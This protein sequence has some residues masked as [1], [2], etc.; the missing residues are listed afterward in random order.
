MNKSKN[1][2]ENI[3]TENERLL[4]HISTSEKKMNDLSS[5]LN[6][7]Y[8]DCLNLYKSTSKKLTSFFD[9]SKVSEVITKTDQNMIFFYQTSLIFLNSFSNI[10]EKFNHIIII[11]LNEYKINYTKENNIIKKDFLLLL[12]DFKKEKRKLI[13]YQNKYYKSLIDYINIKNKYHSLTKTDDEKSYKLYNEMWEKK[14]IMKIQKQL[15][16]YKIG[17]INILYK[18]Y[19]LRYKKYYRS[20]ENNERNRLIFLY[21]TFRIFSLKMK[22]L[23]ESINEFSFQINSKFNEW[24]IEEDKNI[25]KEEFNYIGRYINDE[26]IY[27]DSN[28]VQRFNKEI[29]MPY[30]LQNMNYVNNF[31]NDFNIL[32]RKSSK[33]N[34]ALLEIID[35]NE[36]NNNNNIDELNNKEV[37][38]NFIDK[39][40]EYLYNNNEDI[41]FD[42][43]INII[44]M[45]IKDNNYLNKF[46]NNYYLEN[47][48][49]YFQINRERNI[50]HLAH[51]FLNI[52]YSI[53]E[54]NETDNE[55]NKKIIIKLLKIGQLIYYISNNK[56]KMQNIF[57]CGLINKYFEFQ[58]DKFWEN[59]ILYKIENKLKKLFIKVERNGNKEFKNIK[60]FKE[61]NLDILINNY[62]MFLSLINLNEK[63]N[64]L[65]DEKEKIFF[66]NAFHSLHKIILEFINYLINY[67]FGY[68][69]CIC[70]I[71]KICKKFNLKNELISFY[72][73]YINIISFSSKQYF[74]NF[75]SK[76]KDKL[77][78]IKINSNIN[79]SPNIND[80]NKLLCEKNKIIIILNISKFLNNNYKIKLLRLNKYIYGK[81]HKKIYKEILYFSDKMNEDKNKLNRIHISIWKNLLK[82]SDIKQKYPYEVNKRKIFSKKYLNYEQSDFYIIDLDCQRTLFENRTNTLKNGL[83]PN[84]KGQ[85]FNNYNN[86]NE[87][88]NNINNYQIKSIEMK[89]MSLN[90]ILKTLITLNPEQTYCQ[91]MNFIGVFLLKILNDKEEDT[92]YFMAGLFKYT[93]YPQIF[94]DNL[95]QLKLYFNIFNQLLFIFIPNL[96]DYFK[97]NNIIPNYYLSSCFITLFTNYAKE[98]KLN[99]FIKIFDLFIIDG[100][101]A[102]FNLL[103]DI[104]WH[105]EEK[106]MNLKN[107]NLL[108]YLNGN[109][110]NDFFL[111][112]K[113]YNYFE[114][115]NQRKVTNKLIKNIEDIIVSSNQLGIPFD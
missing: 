3:D 103:L 53:K 113:E 71:K 87:I 72:I 34:D 4:K 15:Y 86:S 6:N 100:W 37:E 20:F 25:I 23:S 54:K 89:R 84:F 26:N 1:Y 9:V 97:S 114:L 78:H 92:F 56:M 32:K 107:E 27:N 82:Y 91:G 52:L 19:D 2:Y 47:K 8:S 98:K 50:K 110:I 62:D 108:H 12:K 46:I 67:N 60:V 29:Y 68:N 66:K 58:N 88:I 44:E 65:S 70:L 7:I 64:I 99:L 39:F 49:K 31:Y 21:N 14:S 69:N 74:Q 11:P 81:I 41:P 94:H 5:F 33:S 85:K 73:S 80:K 77:C 40:Y 102:I 76:L 38:K 109:I 101:K 104:I 35:N 28:K 59:L 45:I 105:N 48:N 106:L 17:A 75:Y 51:I 18:N 112:Y 90:N 13:F 83:S 95:F 79:K 42:I 24:N 111:N 55:E 43:I 61:Y 30:N 10:I 22:E 16:K 36:K 96:Y 93:T 57:L 63:E 115:N